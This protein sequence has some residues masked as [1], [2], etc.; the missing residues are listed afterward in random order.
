M[1]FSSV[2]VSGYKGFIRQD[3]QGKSCPPHTGLGDGQAPA[4]MEYHTDLVLSLLVSLK[5][6]SPSS[7]A[8]T[9]LRRQGE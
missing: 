9:C 7:S 6:R 4:Y 2:T 1:W 3:A 8:E 5:L